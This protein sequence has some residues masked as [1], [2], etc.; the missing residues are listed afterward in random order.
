MNPY[1]ACHPGGYRSTNLWRALPDYA[2][3]LELSQWTDPWSSS[4]GVCGL[5]PRPHCAVAM[6]PCPA[7]TQPHWAS[8]RLRQT[9]PRTEENGT[10]CMGVGWPGCVSGGS[11]LSD[12]E[13]TKTLRHQVQAERHIGASSTTASHPPHASRSADTGAHGSCAYG[14]SRPPTPTECP[15]SR[16][17]TTSR[18]NTTAACRSP[19]HAPARGTSGLPGERG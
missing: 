12:T 14:T 9:G 4:R 15:A 17:P 19:A 7:A 18:T 2:S 10:H 1:Y 8:T 11:N 5:E 13:N 16:T 3:T 6:H